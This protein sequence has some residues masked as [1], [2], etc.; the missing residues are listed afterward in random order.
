LQLW[1]WWDGTVQIAV[2]LPALRLTMRAANGGI[3]SQSQSA[4][5]MA[6]LAIES[7]GDITHPR[8]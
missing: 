6:T 1:Y 4:R 2:L 5:L 7:L 3:V 8:E